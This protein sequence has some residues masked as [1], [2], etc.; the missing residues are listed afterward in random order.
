MKWLVNSI[1]NDRSHVE[2]DCVQMINC[3]VYFLKPMD[4]FGMW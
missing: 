3:A 2:I 1:R 4:S